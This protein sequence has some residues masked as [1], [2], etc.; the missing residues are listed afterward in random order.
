M[1]STSINS[2]ISAL[3]AQSNLRMAG[4]KASRAISALSSGNRIVKASDDVAGLSVGTLLRTNVGTLRTALNNTAQANSLL[5][6]ADGGLQGIGEIVQRQMSLAVSAKAGTLSNSERAYLDQEF[7]ALAAEI[8][9]LAENTKFNQTELLNGAI[10]GRSL[11]VS[12]T[13][14]GDTDGD[15]V[16]P[17]TDTATGTDALNVDRVTTIAAPDFGD[18][19]VASVD[20]SSGGAGATG[21]GPGI[22]NNK[23]FIGN[24]SGFEA[25]YVTTDQVLLSI[26]VGNFTYTTAAPVT[27]T[28]GST[29]SFEGIDNRSGQAGG[30]TFDIVLAALASNTV[31]NQSDANQISAR[32]DT[33]FSTVDVFQ[34][35][36][37]LSYKGYEVGV[38]FASDGTTSIGDLSESTLVMNHD[39]YSSLEIESVS[40]QTATGGG[41]D[42]TIEIV[43]NGETYRSA[44]GI[45][46]SIAAAGSA[47]FTSI[48]NQQHTITFNNVGAVALDFASES[49]AG[50]VQKALEKAL[51][52]GEGNSSLQFQIG[53][54]AE[55][56]ISVAINSAKTDR[57]YDHKDL[58]V[59]TTECRH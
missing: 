4:S 44:A 41:T 45:G 10:Y 24:I 9:R 22:F 8:D 20:L 26:T 16:L 15:G 11:V 19:I 52:L 25:T 55:E 42:G 5:S 36:D 12:N 29:V 31:L 39:D 7:Q 21:I 50:L 13:A 2:N 38:V 14:E 1:A 3:Y 49:N 48:Q 17:G 57:L 30:G 18:A 54:G 46:T 32:L 23:D 43:I 34:E 6:V 53:S 37:I 33:A 59:L 47:T 27:L 40:V 51:G 58:N 56:V 28:A 35:R